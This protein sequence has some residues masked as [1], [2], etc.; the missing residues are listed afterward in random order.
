MDPTHIIDGSPGDRWINDTA[1]VYYQFVCNLASSCGVCIQYHRKIARFWPIPIHRNCRCKQRVVKPGHEAPEPF[2]DFR[3]LLDKMPID[4]QT[5][6][7]GR[8]CYTLL[9]RGV[10]TWEDVVT[11]ARV[12][13]L[14]EVVSIRKLSVE[15]MVK[16]GVQKGIASRAYEQVHT[17][18]HELA[19]RKR[20]ELI[21]VI[22]QA[23]VRHEALVK[24]LAKS[25]AGRTTIA[26]GPSYTTTTDRVAPVGTVI[27]GIEQQA[28]LTPADRKRMTADFLAILSKPEA[29]IAANR[30][31]KAAKAK[32][33]PTPAPRIDPASVRTMDDIVAYVRG[34]GYEV[35][36]VDADEL[37]QRFKWAQNKID[38]APAFYN[39]G[40]RKIYINTAAR[41]WQSPDP[42]AAQDKGHWFARKDLAGLADHEIGHARHHAAIGDRIKLKELN[43]RNWLSFDRRLEVVQAVSGYAGMM[44]NEFVAEVFSALKVG[45]TFPTWVM[46]MYRMYG[47][48]MP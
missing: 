20:Q 16:A 17:P 13:S 29:L 15:R 11:P 39:A 38:S 34:E 21:D 24:H 44:P 28:L 18:E 32:P 3:K 1:T 35:V 25:L 23:G 33:K 30:I 37:R 10:I 48:P 4:Q 26:A 6:A 12:R 8:S 40:D 46:D 45:R 19:A 5:A 22:R 31:I 14:E 43:D 27:P 2:V 36:K 41:R 42:A 9:R 7:V 47:G